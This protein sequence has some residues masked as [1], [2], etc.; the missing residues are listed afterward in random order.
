MTWQQH[1]MRSIP[2]LTMS[3]VA[4]NTASSPRPLQTILVTGL[5]TAMVCNR[6]ELKGA[7]WSAE[8]LSSVDPVTIYYRN[9]MQSI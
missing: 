2:P 4:A 6:M 3:P 8:L 5:D 9:K 1:I 7:V